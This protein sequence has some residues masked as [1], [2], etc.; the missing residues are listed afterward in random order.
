MNKNN[1]FS[2]VALLFITLVTFSCNKEDN[3][4]VL[5]KKLSNLKS[6]NFKN[7]PDE[8][9]ESKENRNLSGGGKELIQI[10]KKSMPID[11]VEVI[12]E[13][14]LDNI[15]P[16]NIL[17]GDSFMEGDLDPIVLINPKK[18]NIS[19]SLQG[20]GLKVKKTA[21]P[22]VSSIRQEMNNLLTDNKIDYHTASSN[23]K[24]E[25]NSVHTYGS[26]NKSFKT[27]ARAN[28]LLGL[29][30]EAFQYETN[31]FSVNETKYVLIKIRQFFYNIAVDP[32][33]YDQWGDIETS[34]LGSYEP[35]YI[36]SV[37]Y[38]RV[39]HLLIKT[40]MSASEISNIVSGSIKA[41]WFLVKTGGYANSEDQTNKMFESNN[42]KLITLGG[43]LGYGKMINNFNLFM[44]FL[45]VPSADELIKSA[46]PIGYKVRS[47]K[48]NKEIEVHTFYTEQR[49]VHQ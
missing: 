30:K 48:D 13:T 2:I 37:D 29:A 8:I 7:I 47:L 11:P 4:N 15:Y 39:A 35:L 46:V 1:L 20:N 40:D 43:P 34:N 12:D 44:Y 5:N 31:E 22:S 38:G 45:M 16:G 26:F 19:I 41:N 6:V 14:K 23:L 32:K 3:T 33:P 21:F 36:S 28:V 9:L 42:V 25:A 27:H 18:I 17:R 24:Y 49:I 10:V